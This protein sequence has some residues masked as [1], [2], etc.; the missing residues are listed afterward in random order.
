[1]PKFLFQGSYA[2]GAGVQALQKEGGTARRA[3]IE[4]LV[5]SLG[6]KLEAFYF[7]FGETDVFVI[8]E[9]PDTVSAA[10]ISLVTNAPGMLSVRTVPLITPEEMDAASK[11]S[12][13]YRPPGG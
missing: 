7:A 8:A 4:Q 5:E 11:K 2:P 3:A 6:G 10:A 13:T 1:M 12:P 9:L